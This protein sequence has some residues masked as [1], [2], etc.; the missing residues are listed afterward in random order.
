MR[1]LQKQQYAM[2]DLLRLGPV[3]KGRSKDEHESRWLDS[4]VTSRFNDSPASLMLLHA[5]LA[6]VVNRCSVEYVYRALLTLV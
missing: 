3:D 4:L 6:A 1:Q 5:T 2:D